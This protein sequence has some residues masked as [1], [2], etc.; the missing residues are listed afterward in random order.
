MSRGLGLSKV[1][2]DRL[3]AVQTRLQ[4]ELALLLKEE[5]NRYCAD[6]DAKGPRWASWNL[7]VFLCIRC[8]GIHRNLGVHIS[9]VKSVNLDSWT[10]E[11]VASVRAMGNATARSVYEANLPE[12]F[13]RPASD[14]ATEA[15][16]RAKYDA[17]RYIQ[18][19]WTRPAV[20]ERDLP[21]WQ[22]LQDIKNGVTA[23]KKAQK[24][25]LGTAPL[26][27][28]ATRTNA[29][30]R[31]PVSP[32]QAKAPA[33]QSPNQS[34]AAAQNPPAQ[35][36]SAVNDLL[37]LSTP[38]P[39]PAAVAASGGVADLLGLDSG[40]GAATSPVHAAS[41]PP[42]ASAPA[43]A[44]L[45]GGAP[46]SP[47]QTQPPPPAAT[48]EALL[49]EASATSPAAATSPAGPKSN[50]DILALFGSSASAQPPPAMNMNM[51]PSQQSVSMMSSQQP[52]QMMPAQQSAMMGG[53]YPPQMG[54]GYT[55]PSQ[56]FPNIMAQGFPPQSQGYGGQPAAAFGGGYAGAPGGFPAQAFPAQQQLPAQTAAANAAFAG[57]TPQLGGMSLGGAS[58][59]PAP[60]AQTNSF[61]TNLWQ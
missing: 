32:A 40:G 19:G 24:V 53:A 8:A 42:N 47:T 61:A 15:F 57:L 17:K 46:A 22:E 10:A 38:A 25:A 7:G 56:P 1:E 13:R 30:V 26:P 39:G 49:L 55:S 9:K 18:K 44:A 58:A 12:H 2:Q 21:C 36:P 31:P 29:P 41:L 23:R 3:K 5:E 60:T 34:S 51:A 59:A 50:T 16:I 14:S 35:S 11:Q 4:E 54:A 52:A 48:N 45:G 20:S 37:G 27:S 43:F 28:G 6:C 33:P